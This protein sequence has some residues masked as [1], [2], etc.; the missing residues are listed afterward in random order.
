MGDVVPEARKME[1]GGNWG[2]NGG[3]ESSEEHEEYDSGIAYT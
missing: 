1:K 2:R 3:R